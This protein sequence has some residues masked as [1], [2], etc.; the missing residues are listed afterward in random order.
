MTIKEAERLI[1]LTRGIERMRIKMNYLSNEY[2][3]FSR[4]FRA[5]LH[6][7]VIKKDF[8]LRWFDFPWLF[9]EVIAFGKKKRKGIRNE[10]AFIKQQIEL[11]NIEITQLE[12]TEK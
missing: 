5:V 7:L 1:F 11:Y 3:A 8:R 4:P 6:H 9:L 10:I 2:E 12:E